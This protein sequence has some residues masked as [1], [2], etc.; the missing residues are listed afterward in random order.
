MTIYL[1]LTLSL[2][3]FRIGADDHDTTLTFDDSA[4]IADRLDGSS[5][6][7]LDFSFSLLKSVDDTAIGDIVRGDF[8]GDLITGQNADSIHTHLAGDSGADHRTAV[9][10]YRVLAGGKGLKNGSFHSDEFFSAHAC[11]T[12]MSCRC[13]LTL[14][15]IDVIKGPFS[16]MMTSFS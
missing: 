5:D 6:F 13:R 12:S 11:F 15:S 14:E 1:S 4:L 2:L 9:K 8:N 7:H 3:M 16:W 10:L